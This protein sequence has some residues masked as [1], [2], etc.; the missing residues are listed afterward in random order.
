MQTL[1]E[2]FS[3]AEQGRRLFEEGRHQEALDRFELALQHS[4]DASPTAISDVLRCVGKI[5]NELRDFDD[6]I[7]YYSRLLSACTSVD[8]K[9]IILNRLGLLHQAKRDYEKALEYGVQCLAVCR[10]LGNRRWEAV[11]L[12]NLGRLHSILGNHVKALKCHEES[13]RLKRELGDKVGEATSLL[14]LAGDYE[15]AGMFDEAIEKLQ[16]ALEIYEELGLSEQVEHVLDDID[17][18]EDLKDQFLEEEE[19]LVRGTRSPRIS[20]HDFFTRFA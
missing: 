4:D 11:T 10:E 19:F 14:Y 15:D 12:R 16:A 17:R 18:L 8:G 13:L 2:F 7:A 3:L 1:D 6:A 5:Y 9:P 20:G